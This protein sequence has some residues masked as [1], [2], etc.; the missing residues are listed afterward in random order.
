VVTVPERAAA[1][2]GR[3]G[4]SSP[5]AVP[6]AGVRRAVLAAEERVVVHAL[7]RVLAPTLGCAFVRVPGGVL[8]LGAVV[9]PDAPVGPYD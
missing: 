7:G 5:A 8:V 1:S 3:H 9:G 6:S 4:E 2:A